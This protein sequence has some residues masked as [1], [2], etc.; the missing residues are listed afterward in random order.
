[1]IGNV[2]NHNILLILSNH[3]ELYVRVGV[4]KVVAVLVQRYF[5]EDVK[6]LAD[7]NYFFHLANQLS[8]YQASIDLVVA[9]VSL[10]FGNEVALDNI[11]KDCF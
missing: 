6:K 10:I 8:L 11:V 4:V 2:F 1:M 5:A 7:S 9:C 3:Q